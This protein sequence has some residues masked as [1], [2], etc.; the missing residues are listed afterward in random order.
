MNLTILRSP[1]I[2][3]G[4]VLFGWMCF[5]MFNLCRFYSS[6]RPQ[7]L[8]QD[9]PAVL[10]LKYII[11]ANDTT[12]SCDLPWLFCAAAVS[13]VAIL[14]KKDPASSSNFDKLN[15]NNG[16]WEL[17]SHWS[18]KLPK[19]HLLSIYVL[20]LRNQRIAIM[21]FIIK[22][23]CSYLLL[24]WRQRRPSL[25][26]KVVLVGQWKRP[27]PLKYQNYTCSKLCEGFY[28]KIE[29]YCKAAFSLPVWSISVD[30]E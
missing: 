1:K 26:V 18:S 16:V 8:F 5:C 2:L 4:R 29:S 15:L 27:L 21:S 20:V 28:W 10:V 17:L 24:C 7:R 3:R 13:A 6:S 12:K 22:R 9:C 14:A 23:I 19:L 11:L 25:T 30:S